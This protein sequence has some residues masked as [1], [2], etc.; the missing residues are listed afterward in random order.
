MA[1]KI[2][3]VSVRQR[4]CGELIIESVTIIEEDDEKIK[5]IV[6]ALKPGA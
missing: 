5:F 2:Y 1:N 3:D 4:Y 6:I